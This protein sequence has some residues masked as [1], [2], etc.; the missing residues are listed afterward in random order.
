MSRPIAILRPEPGNR[1]TAQA[2]QAMGLSVIRLPLF[3]VEPVAWDVPAPE[4]FDALI[5][6]SA[7]AV[8]HGGAGMQALRALPVRAVGAAT[9]RAAEQAGFR[10]AA[11]GQTDAR[12]L[13]DEAER[14]GVRR[15]LLLAGQE[16]S[17][18]AGGIVAVARTV[19]A[20]V[21]A[22]VEA[23]ALERLRDGV[24]M[25]HSTRAAR[26]LAALTAGDA[27]LRA[28]IEAVAISAKAAAALDHGWAHVEA[29]PTPDADA[30]LARAR[31]LAIDP[32]R[33]GGNM[34]A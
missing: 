4:L 24:V 21:A 1:A 22:P 34:V 17:I 20:S 3:R 5:L 33:R 8:R 32:P 27:A 23:A 15:A 29:L 31:V 25:L 2:A 11:I 10:V 13:L 12:A 19:Y 14:A 18:D 7:N 28:S 6:T 30:L 26:R 9:A 16:R